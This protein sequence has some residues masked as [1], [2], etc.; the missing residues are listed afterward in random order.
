M[1]GVVP[2]T[3]SNKAYLRTTSYFTKPSYTDRYSVC[4]YLGKD[5]VYGWYKFEEPGILPLEY[6]DVLQYHNQPTGFDVFL[7]VSN[8]IHDCFFGPGLLIERIID[9]FDEPLERLPFKPKGIERTISIQ[10]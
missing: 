4:C 2:Y 10:N 7:E 3:S 8:G 5:A 6:F 9:S 1:F